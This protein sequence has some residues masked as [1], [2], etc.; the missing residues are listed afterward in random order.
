MGLLNYLANEQLKNYEVE[1][2]KVRLGYIALNV[3]LAVKDE[4]GN[5]L[6]NN[7]EVA[8]LKEMSSDFTKE[9]VKIDLEIKGLKAL[10]KEH[11]TK[12]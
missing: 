2:E 12:E 5:C 1:K 4:K 10:I 6:F 11:E 7:K 9:A 8:I 3:A